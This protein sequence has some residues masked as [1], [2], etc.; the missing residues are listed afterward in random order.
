M[1]QSPLAPPRGVHRLLLSSPA[2]FVGEYLGENLL[3]SQAFP[4]GN[5]ELWSVHSRFSG[6]SPLARTYVVATFP[7]SLISSEDAGHLAI[8]NN[9]DYVGDVF[10]AVLSIFFGKRFDRHGLFES[11]GIFEVPNLQ[12]L[13]PVF[14]RQLPFNSDSPRPDLPIELNLAHVA[15]VVGI[16]FDDAFELRFRQLLVSAGR[17]YVRALRLYQDDPEL[18]FIDLVTCGEVLASFFDYEQAELEDPDLRSVLNR[19]ESCA[20]DGVSLRKSVE[21]RLHFIRRRYTRSLLAL[22][23]PAFFDRTEASYDHVALKLADIET[24]LKASYDLRSLYLHTGVRF[25]NFLQP[26]QGIWEVFTEGLVVE[27]PELAKALTRSP[28]FF[29]LERVLRFCLLRFL[30]LHATPIHS[31]LDGEGLE[32]SQEA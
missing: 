11:N 6:A 30:H 10:C 29:G 2:P 18:A 24:R 15:S 27:P 1:S 19:I 25:A 17:Y 12:N 7:T 26:I 31:S 8:L 20:P 13:P 28:T 3:L 21:K 5:L 22:L 23:T 32:P 14:N 16:P 9:Q 4:L